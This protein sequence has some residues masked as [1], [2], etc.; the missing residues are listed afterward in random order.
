M[1]DDR[2]RNV[3]R[4][5]STLQAQ[6]GTAVRCCYFGESWW[7]WPPIAGSQWFAGSGWQAE[8]ARLYEAAADVEARLK[9]G[10]GGG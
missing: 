9:A 3:Y 8:T 2:T 5:V 1:L 4:A 6:S 10:A 7:N